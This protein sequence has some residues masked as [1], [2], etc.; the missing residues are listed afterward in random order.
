MQIKKSNVNEIKYI[1]K[2]LQE[3]N[4]KYITDCE[5]I[6]YYIED[7]K[8]NLIAGIV[9]SRDLECITI[10]YLFVDE[11]YRK[12]KY[13]SILL[14]YLE[15]EA[16][17]KNVRRIVLSTFSFQAPEFYKNHG[18]EIFGI[19]KPCLKNYSEYYFKKEL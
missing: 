5:D 8:E 18:Y 13:G 17:E 11:N 15:K 10:D 14:E 4:S 7:E 1:H 16:K 9:A 19:I 6:S 12:N 3:Y 2:K